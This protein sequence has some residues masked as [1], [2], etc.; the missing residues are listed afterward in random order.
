MTNSTGSS[1]KASQTALWATSYGIVSVLI[2][3]TNMVSIAAFIKTKPR[4]KHT[5]YFL[6]NLSIADF[7]VGAVSVPLFVS[8]VVGSEAWTPGLVLPMVYTSVD[9]LSGL[10]S[11]FT[12]AI[13]SV[14]RLI[15]VSIPFKFRMISRNV[16]FGC[17][18]ATWILSACVAAMS[19]AF[20]LRIIKE[21]FYTVVI[22]SLTLSLA[23]ACSGYVFI[24]LKINRKNSAKGC[25]DMKLEQRLS[26]TLLCVTAIFVFSWL[27]FELVFILVH[28]CKTCSLSTNAVFLIKLLH[29]SNSFM[30]AVVYTFRIPEF[31]EALVQMFN[32]SSNHSEGHDVLLQEFTYDVST[33]TSVMRLHH[34]TFVTVNDA[35]SPAVSPILSGRAPHTV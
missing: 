22:L 32:R 13:V 8:Y 11:V 24:I 29:Y 12:L 30:N 15:A 35:N 23:V 33:C 1:S 20:Y 31:K 21:A 6:I 26:V 3:V 18:A 14:E 9:I 10:A 4:R 7:M 34:Q 28:F 27:P 5:H 2:V 16:Y 25:K 19:V 17:I